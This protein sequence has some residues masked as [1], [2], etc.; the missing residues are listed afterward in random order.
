MKKILSQILI[1]GLL[2]TQ[3]SADYL[4]YYGDTS[5]ETLQAQT[6]QSSGGAG[7]Q[8]SWEDTT[9]RVY[10]PNAP[11]NYGSGTLSIQ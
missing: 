10:N 5:V 4:W 1:G 6:G 7:L 3:A 11:D 9:L 8:V 2:I